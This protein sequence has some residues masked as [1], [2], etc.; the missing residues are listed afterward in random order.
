MFGRE[1]VNS[2]R[3]L[4]LKEI[5][6]KS[7]RKE[8]ERRLVSNWEKDKRKER[9]RFRDNKKRLERFFEEKEDFKL[10]KVVEVFGLLDLKCGNFKGRNERKGFGIFVSIG[11]DWMLEFLN[12]LFL[13]FIKI[14]LE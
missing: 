2:R 13:D 7:K 6:F 5:G 4:L 11:E 12:I 1:V 14:I 9:R 3:Y 10:I 8:S